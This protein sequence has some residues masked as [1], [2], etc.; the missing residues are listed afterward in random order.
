MK[1]ENNMQTLVEW[2]ANRERLGDMQNGFKVIHNKDIF[3]M[4]WN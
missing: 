1:E 2:V 3:I 4:K